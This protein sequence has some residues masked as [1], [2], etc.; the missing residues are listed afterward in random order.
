MY[1]RFTASPG[2]I[3]EFPTAKSGSAAIYGGL[4]DIIA[5]TPMGTGIHP[6]GLFGLGGYVRHVSVTRTPGVPATF[7]DPF[8]G[9]SNLAVPAN[10][11]GV[12]ATEVKFGTSYGGGIAIGTPA[13]SFFAEI[14]YHIIFTNVD[15]TDLLPITLGIRF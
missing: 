3:N 2:L 12:A 14:R 15:H 10:A 8:A 9:F 5:G 11:T 7:N 1:D 6:Y 4:F 13:V